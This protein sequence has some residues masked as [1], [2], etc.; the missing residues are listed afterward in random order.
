MPDI[1]AACSRGN[2]NEPTF[3]ATIWKPPP[4]KVEN[5]ISAIAT[6]TD[7]VHV[8]APSVSDATVRS[9]NRPTGLVLLAAYRSAAQPQ[10][11]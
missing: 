7:V 4:M 3:S 5:E 6:G 11:K 9:R 1:I 8:A 2:A 10:K